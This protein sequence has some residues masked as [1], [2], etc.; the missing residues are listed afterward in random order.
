MK[1]Y[2]KSTHRV[3]LLPS[4]ET[5]LNLELSLA[6]C[7]KYWYNSSSVVTLVLILLR[8]KIKYLLNSVLTKSG[9]IAN[10]RTVKLKNTKEHVSIFTY[11]FKNTIIVNISLQN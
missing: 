11:L 7:M 10:R 4:G 2:S 9:R 5:K 3:D 6:I 8:I 1:Y